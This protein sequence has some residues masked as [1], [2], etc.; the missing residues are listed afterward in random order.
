MT[1]VGPSF[2]TGIP[3]ISLYF[4]QII[5]ELPAPIQNQFQFT[6]FNETTYERNPGL[7]KLFSK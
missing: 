1:E 7:A 5:L 4:K 3:E 2:M 6:F